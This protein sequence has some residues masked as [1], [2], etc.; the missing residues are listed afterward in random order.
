MKKRNIMLGSIILLVALLVLGT[1]AW[2]TDSSEVVNSFK[3][4]TVDIDLIENGITVGG[5]FNGINIDNVNPG[6]NHEK[7]IEVLSNGSKQ[8]YVRVKL[9]PTWTFEDE[10]ADNTLA[11]AEYVGLDSSKWILSGDYYYYHKI[12]NKDDITDA[13]ITGIKFNGP[14]MGNDYQGATFTLEVKAEAVQASYKAYETEWGI[15]DL[16]VGVEEWTE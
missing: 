15:S 5:E 9:T 12:L 13:L 6:D 3:A 14:D 7:E 1:M 11:P 2:F 4:G 16:P 8:T 10:T